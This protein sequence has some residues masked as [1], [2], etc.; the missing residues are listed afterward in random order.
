MHKGTG[1]KNIQ[2]YS[3]SVDENEIETPG[4]KKNVPYESVPV[5]TDSSRSHSKPIFIISCLVKP[6]AGCCDVFSKQYVT[7]YDYKFS[8]ILGQH[9]A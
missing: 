7:E 3:K 8:N 1:K 4:S 9:V 6:L 2:I 5:G